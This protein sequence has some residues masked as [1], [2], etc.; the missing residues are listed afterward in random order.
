M[1]G[2][3]QE[4][5]MEGI[6][7]KY[8]DQGM[9]QAIF[10]SMLEDLVAG[11]SAGAILAVAGVYEILS[12]H[13]NNDIVEQW[14]NDHPDENE[15]ARDEC[16][17]SNTACT[18]YLWECETCGESYCEE[19]SHETDKGANVECVACERERIQQEG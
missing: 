1:I 7:C 16:Y 6:M 2:T 15:E 19:H 8:E 18:G 11:M 13:F 10:N 9:T 5:F 4:I 3:R 14:D 12:E 17:Y